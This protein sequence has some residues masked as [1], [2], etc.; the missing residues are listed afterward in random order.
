[1]ILEIRTAID[2]PEGDVD[3]NRKE[4]DTPSKALRWFQRTFFKSAQEYLLTDGLDDPVNDEQAHNQEVFRRVRAGMKELA[5]TPGRTTM[6]KQKS[7]LRVWNREF[8]GRRRT[9]V[10]LRVTDSCAGPRRKRTTHGTRRGR[11]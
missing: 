11:A 6:A 2:N 5:R 3:I 9:G 7:L 8:G 1:M 10:H 4:F